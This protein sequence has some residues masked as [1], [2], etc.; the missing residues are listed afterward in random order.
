MRLLFFLIPNLLLSNAFAADCVIG[1]STSIPVGCD[2][3]T[4][5]GTLNLSAQPG[6][7]TISATGDVVINGTILLDGGNGTT[8]SAAGSSGGSAGPGANPG[9]GIDAFSTPESGNGSSPTA[10]DG[11]FGTFITCAN[12]GGGGGLY[13][14]GQNGMDCSQSP[15][16]GA[17]GAIAFGS[18]F[19]FGGSFRGGFGGGAG[20][21]QS[22]TGA[23]GGGGGALKI[24]ANNVTINSSGKIS[25]RGGNGGNSTSDGGGGGGGSGG[26]LWIVTTTGLISNKGTIDLRGGDGGKNTTGAHG[27]GGKGGDGV[28]QFED[29]TGTRNGSGLVSGSGGS[30][31]TS[32]IT[33][34]TI[35]KVNEEHNPTLFYQIILGFFFGLASFLPR[36][37]RQK[38]KTN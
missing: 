5:N 12:G 4:I 21:L 7:I 17:G 30:K 31:L 34:G 10:S 25:A 29:L 28:Y 13:T 33:C 16:G 18:L 32:D 11:T 14:V 24:E 6:P 1:N 35:A 23:G 26:A 3:L 36:K 38:I 9:G 2:N 27:N 20:S 19:D 15:N 8:V 22:E 37:V